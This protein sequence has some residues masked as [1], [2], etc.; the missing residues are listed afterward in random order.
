M[1]D[2]HAPHMAAIKRILRSQRYPHSWCSH[3]GVSFSIPYGVL[4]RRLGR[5]PRYTALHFSLLCFLGPNLISWSSKQQVSTSRSSAEAEYRV[6]ANATAETGWL[7]SFLRELHCPLPQPTLIYCDNISAV[8]LSSNQVHHQRTQH[9][10]I[11]IN[12]CGKR[13]LL[14]MLDIS[15]FHPLVRLR[16]SSP[17]AYQRRYLLSLFHVLPFEFLPFRLQGRVRVRIVLEFLDYIL[18]PYFLIL[19]R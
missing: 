2:P 15:I 1:H 6:I 5:L 8:Y 13:S 19:P 12:L 4:R 14:V 11:D 3:P 7:H 16:I 9:V 18:F 17:K 10:E